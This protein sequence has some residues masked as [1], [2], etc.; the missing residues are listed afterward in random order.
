[1]ADKTFSLGAILS[2]TTGILLCD[3]GEVH[4]LLDHMTGDALFT[5]QLPRAAREC[6][7]P[8]RDQFPQLEG[9]EVPVSLPS[10]ELY[11]QWVETLHERYGE[12]HE[13]QPMRPGEHTVINPFDELAMNYAHVEIIPVVADT[14]ADG[15]ADA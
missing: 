7:G 1:V 11:V 5:Y 9:I 8:L 3:F 14:R 4:E 2:V 6:E 10:P 12:Q 13:V 15:D